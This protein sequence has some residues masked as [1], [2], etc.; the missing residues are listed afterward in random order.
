M[1][2]LLQE[3]EEM[4]VEKY[5]RDNTTQVIFIAFSLGRDVIPQLA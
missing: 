2:I 4:S 3:Q 1:H 5:C